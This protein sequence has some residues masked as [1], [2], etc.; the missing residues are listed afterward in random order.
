MDSM[1]IEPIDVVVLSETLDLARVFSD[2][3]DPRIRL[4]R[5]QDVAN[6]D[7]IEYALAWMP[8]ADMFEE[9][10]NIKMISSVAAGVDSIL[11]CRTLPLDVA[12]CRI[13]DD[14]QARLMAEFAAWN[15]IWFHRRMGDFLRAQRERKWVRTYRPPLFSDVTVG[16]LGFG[17]MGQACARL[18][19]AMDFRFWP[20][21][22]RQ[23][24]KRIYPA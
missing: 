1:T 22:I 14:E 8:P 13:R 5:P 10:P 18:I 23:V 11:S 15:V 16:I 9:F 20:R 2:V 3:S 21:G 12:V 4:I 7:A 17:L 6:P 19:A 24:R